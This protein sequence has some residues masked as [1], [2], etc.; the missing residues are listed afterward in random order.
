[1]RIKHNLT[2][3]FILYNHYSKIFIRLFCSTQ[4]WYKNNKFDFCVGLSQRFNVGAFANIGGIR[5]KN[6]ATAFVFVYGTQDRNWNTEYNFSN[7]YLRNNDN[8]ASHEIAHLLGM[9]EEFDCANH[10]T[11]E[12]KPWKIDSAANMPQS[13]CITNTTLGGIGNCFSYKT[14][15]RVRSSMSNLT[16][17]WD[18]LNEATN[19]PGKY[20]SGVRLRVDSLNNKDGRY[21]ITT[22]VKAKSEATIG[23]LYENGILIKSFP[24]GTT[25]ISRRDTF[26]NKSGNFRYRS[27]IEGNSQIH[28]SDS[29]SVKSTSV[30]INPCRTTYSNWSVCSTNFQSRSFIQTGNNCINPPQDS[31]VRVCSTSMSIDVNGTSLNNMAFSLSRDNIITTNASRWVTIG[32]AS[33]TFNNVNKN[34]TNLILHTGFLQ[35]NVWTNPVKSIQVI[36]NGVVIFNIT[37]NTNPNLIIPINTNTTSLRILFRDTDNNRIREIIF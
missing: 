35:N 12:G 30:I 15:R 9:R 6:L 4:S 31:L 13:T 37:N 26:T 18:G 22:I 25:A 16:L 24:I 7:T 3:S 19:I 2:A 20:L 14:T 1:M 34:I 5:Q 10:F 23:R 27:Q 33:V 29:F 11:P 32:P 8:A 36:V 21:I 17:M 28:S